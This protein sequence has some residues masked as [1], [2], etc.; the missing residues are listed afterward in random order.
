MAKATSIAKKRTPRK[1]RAKT[2]SKAA[3]QPAG[4]PDPH[5]IVQLNERMNK[6]IKQAES[7]ILSLSMGMTPQNKEQVCSAIM[8]E[9]LG[10]RKLIEGIVLV[11]ENVPEDIALNF[12]VNEEKTEIHVWDVAQLPPPPPAMKPR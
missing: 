7:R 9:N 1:S 3:P 12:E 4:K 6:R 2:K 5:F 10:Y 11:N 8:T